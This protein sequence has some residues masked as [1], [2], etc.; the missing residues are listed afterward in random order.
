MATPR[1][2]ILDSGIGG[3]SILRELAALLPH[4]N[5]LYIADQAHLPYGTRPLEEVQQYTEAITRYMLAQ[6]VKIIVVACNTASA[7]ALYHLREVF[8]AM[9]FVGMEPAVRPAAQGTTQGKI[10]VIATA[11][12]FQGQLYASL[13]ERFAADIEVITRACPELVVLAERGGAWT[14]NDYA[15][16]WELMADIRA[17]QADQLVLGCTHFAF[18]KPLLQAALGEKVAIIDPAPA[19]ARQAARVLAQ[20]NVAFDNGRQIGQVEYLTTGDLHVFS[21]Q[22][23]QLIGDV[24]QTAI[25]ALRWNQQ[26][27]LLEAMQ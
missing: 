3:L 20:Q 4:E 23:E 26:T 13:V 15:F 21:T 12:T 16:V 1:I 6:G 24:P 10:A 18:V 14:I 2:G 8:P 5:L 11:A 9:S 19:V 22:A 17:S 27:S 25:A 7:A